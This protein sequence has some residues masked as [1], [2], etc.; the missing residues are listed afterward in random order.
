LGDNVDRGELTLSAAQD[1]AQKAL[2]GNSN[3]LYKLKL[4]FKA[5]PISTPFINVFNRELHPQ[6]IASPQKP[7]PIS[8]NPKG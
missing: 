2:F 7:Q 5:L 6:Q 8:S 4:S 1:I 3:T